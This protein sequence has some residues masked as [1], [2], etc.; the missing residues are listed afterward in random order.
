MSS[1]RSNVAPDESLSLWEAFRVSPSETAI[2]ALVEYYLP[3]V[4]KTVAAMTVYTRP[5]MDRDDLLQYAVMGLW[6]TIE[7]FDV[8]RG[9]SFQSYVVPRIRGAVLDAL[10]RHDPLTRT[11]RALLKT[12]QKC[13][14]TYAEQSELAPDEDALADNAGITVEALQSLTAR[15]QPFLSLDVVA[16]EDAH[17]GGGQS[18]AGQLVDE[19]APDPR[20]E[21]FRHE[22]GDAFRKAFRRLPDRQQKLLYLYYY[23]DLTLKDIGG[24]LDLTEARICQLHSNALLLLRAMMSL[25]V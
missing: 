5:D 2:S 23:E 15:A 16:F 11:D 17:G 14:A 1:R 10:R 20:L 19:S 6:S 3:L 12:I 7:R 8:T 21:T 9:I 18:L 4:R 24:I 25:Y 22:Q 13:A